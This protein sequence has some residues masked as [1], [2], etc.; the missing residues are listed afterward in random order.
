MY[1]KVIV[2]M[3]RVYFKVKV[4]EN[5]L[6]CYSCYVHRHL[7]KECKMGKLCRTCD[8]KHHMAKECMKK[9]M[10]Q[11]L[12]ADRATFGSL[13]TSE[14]VPAVYERLVTYERTYRND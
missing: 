14:R 13:C 10:L 1:E 4:Y 12:L 6:Q 11:T 9:G 8:E 7:S 3:S 5:I 2:A